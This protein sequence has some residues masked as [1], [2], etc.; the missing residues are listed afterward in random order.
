MSKIISLLCAGCMCIVGLPAVAAGV[1][2]RTDCTAVGARISELS[3]IEN[4]DATVADELA[5]LQATYRRDCSIS[6]AGRRTS[7]RSAT[8]VG[9]AGTTANTNVDT[10]GLTVDTALSQFLTDKQKICK[11]L[12]SNIA[13]LIT[14]GATDADLQPL[15]DTYHTDCLGEPAPATTDDTD[16]ASTEPVDPETAAANMA[17]G[18]CPDGSQPNRFGCCA[19]ETFKD[20]GNL[21]FACCPDDGSECHTPINSGT[22]L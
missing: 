19:G 6:T 3:A 10:S 20:M 7:G 15:V 17:A 4:P 9:A 5:Q 18:L 12:S 22:L 2:E 11:D 1:T 8:N 13:A 14:T 21:V 16:S